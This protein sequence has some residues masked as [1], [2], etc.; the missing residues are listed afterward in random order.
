MFDDIDKDGKRHEYEY[1][2][3]S[4][5]VSE[6]SARDDASF[7]V[8]TEAGAAAGRIEVLNPTT[9]RLTAGAYTTTNGPFETHA[10]W[11]A[12]CTSKDPRFVVLHSDAHDGAGAPMH[13]EVLTSDSRVI[14]R[15]QWHYGRDE[16]TFS[17]LGD[18]SGPTLPILDRG[19]A[20]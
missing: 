7:V 8:R 1:R 13:A 15:L 16:I 14:V 11:S 3:H 6:D 18:R 20:S 2:L 10:L 5:Y 9:V 4:P 17:G 12:T 19:G